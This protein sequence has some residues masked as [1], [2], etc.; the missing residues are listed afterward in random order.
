MNRLR[1]GVLGCA[2]IA[3]RRMLPALAA[4]PSVEP[5]AVASRSADKA[6][7]TAARF[8]LIPVTGYRNLLDR[9][10]IDAVYLPLPIGLH[11]RWIEA[12]L[13]AGKH[14]LAEKSLSVGIAE[15]GPLVEQARAAGLLLMES[16]MFV[17]HSQHETIR[18][19]VADGVIGEPR[20]FSAAFGI[21][22]RP[23][24][25]FRNH[26]D[27]GG[28][29]LLDVGTYPIRA[30]QLFLG[31][32]LSVEG[33]VLCEDPRL[34][35]DVAGHALLSTPDRVTADLSFGFDHGYRNTYSLWGSRGR[36]S[37]D[38]AFTPPDDLMPIVRIEDA[39]GV[40]ELT[41]PPDRPFVKIAEAFARTV[42][43]GRDFGPAG[44]DVL[45]QAA[46]LTA[47]RYA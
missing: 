35:V 20:V 32:D 21:P 17:H 44:T 46:L 43:D 47:V 38:R 26:R 24:D 28:G 19:L 14:V 42:L 33:A 41:L 29:A 34:G 1:F 9:D 22:P 16:F 10:D 18:G 7:D 15:A 39:D 27:L 11:A 2:S 6:A 31:A 23:P 37:L 45:R 3:R 12:A 13:A 36:I 4:A 5:V 40:R 25:D 30:A 8:G